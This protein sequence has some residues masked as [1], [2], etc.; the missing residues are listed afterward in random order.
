[1]PEPRLVPRP[2]DL[3]I[4]IYNILINIKKR[5]R[6]EFFPVAIRNRWG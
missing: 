1:M 5:I 3:L 4:G 6:P 2:P